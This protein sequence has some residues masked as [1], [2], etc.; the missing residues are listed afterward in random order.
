MFDGVNS[1]L[2]GVAATVSLWLIGIVVLIWV[3]IAVLKRLVR[4]PAP[5]AQTADGSPAPRASGGITSIIGK[6]AIVG[7]LLFGGYKAWDYFY[8]PEP[9]QKVTNKF[10]QVQTQLAV[11]RGLESDPALPSKRDAVPAGADTPTTSTYALPPQ[12]AAPA[13]PQKSG[14]TPSQSAEPASAALKPIV[15]G[16][17]LELDKMIL[18]PSLPRPLM[19]TDAPPRSALTNR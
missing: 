19:T 11:K 1:Y 2:I 3:I 7:V 12:T 15:G 16:R 5:A 8:Q 4:G 6:L 14:T 17:Y 10:D 18:N 9:S 13:T